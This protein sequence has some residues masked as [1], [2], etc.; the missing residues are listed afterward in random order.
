MSVIEDLRAA[1]DIVAKGWYRGWVTDGKGNYC[2]V[3]ALNK[4]SGFMDAESPIPEHLCLR[5]DQ[6]YEV[7]RA[8]LPVPYREVAEYNDAKSTTHQDILNLF[9]KALADL[10]GLA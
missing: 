10:G 9:D 3:G 5:R 8:Y 6:A 1:K 4:V 7:L 2:A